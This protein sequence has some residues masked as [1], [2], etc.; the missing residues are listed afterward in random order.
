MTETEH[1]WLEKSLRRHV[2][3][4]FAFDPGF[5]LLLSDSPECVRVGQCVYGV[6]L[7]LHPS[8]SESCTKSLVDGALLFD[9]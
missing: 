2:A 7:V 1:A 6:A 8:L 3:L 5:V 9:L 4:A